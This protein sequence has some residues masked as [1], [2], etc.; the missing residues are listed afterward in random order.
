MGEMVRGLAT[1]FGN[2]KISQETLMDVHGFYHLLPYFSFFYHLLP[3]FTIFYDLLPSFTIFIYLPLAC[4]KQ[5]VTTWGFHSLA[6]AIIAR[7][8]R[9]KRRGQLAAS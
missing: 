5:V 3:S 7:A 8:K 1:A 4:L 6:S 9:R 2:L